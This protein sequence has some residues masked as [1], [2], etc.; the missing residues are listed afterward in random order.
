L[1]V[2]IIASIFEEIIL[3]QKWRFHMP[4]IELIGDRNM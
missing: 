4:G 2:Y 3:L 1:T